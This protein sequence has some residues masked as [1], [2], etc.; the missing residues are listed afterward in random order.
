MSGMHRFRP[1][2]PGYAVLVRGERS[3]PVVKTRQGVLRCAYPGCENEP[4]PGAAQGA[5]PGYC[6]LPDPVTGQP[7]TALTA[8]RRRQLLARHD[9][10]AAGPPDPARPGSAFRRRRARA[11]A[12]AGVAHAAAQQADARLAEAL[13]AKAAAEQ[14]AEAARAQIAR[15]RRAAEERAAAAESRARNAGQDAAR[16]REAAGRPARSWTGPAGRGRQVTQARQDTA[17]DQ[18]GLRAGSK[19]RSRRQSRPGPPCRP[20]PSTPRLSCSVPARTVTRQPGRPPGQP[21]GA[22]RRRRGSPGT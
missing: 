14:E 5:E 17:R 16:A 21:A 9:R 3:L 10:G 19:R 15:A 7:H 4:Q 8:F 1:P 22:T 2:G 13:T 18:A 20:A 11:E 12:E 6:G